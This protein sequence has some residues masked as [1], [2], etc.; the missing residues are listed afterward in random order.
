MGMAEIEG[1]DWDSAN[2]AHILRHGVTPFE[3][4]EA[5]VRPHVTI[6]A[7]TIGGEGR[8]KLFGKAA[9]NR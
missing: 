3:V 6:P 4:E 7:K 5:A 9:S 1:F 2:T 8:W